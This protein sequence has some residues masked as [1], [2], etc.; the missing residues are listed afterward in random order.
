M[1]IL[2]IYQ[3]FSISDIVVTSEQ[4]IIMRVSEK[5]ID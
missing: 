4:L 1:I 2:V 3:K 5:K